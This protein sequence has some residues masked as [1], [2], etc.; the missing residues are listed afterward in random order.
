[1]G[2]ILPFRKP[3]DYRFPITL[4]IP[5]FEPSGNQIG[6]VVIGGVTPEIWFLY[7]MPQARENHLAQGLMPTM[8]PGSEWDFELEFAWNEAVRDTVRDTVKLMTEDFW[9]QKVI[10]LPPPATII[11]WDPLLEEKE[12]GFLLAYGELC[13]VIWPGIIRPEL[14]PFLPLQCEFQH[15]PEEK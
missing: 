5:A 13:E 14:M 7:L 6:A 4:E 12:N 11:V 10:R 3:K 9:P 8:L 1:M 2:T 15:P